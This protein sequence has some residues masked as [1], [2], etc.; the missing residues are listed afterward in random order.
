LAAEKQFNQ[1]QTAEEE[2]KRESLEAER[3]TQIILQA[4]K[5]VSLEQARSNLLFFSKLDLLSVDADKLNAV[6]AEGLT[7]QTGGAVN[8]DLGTERFIYRVKDDEVHVQIKFGLES[9]G[10]STIKLDTGLI[11]KLKPTERAKLGPGNELIGSTLFIAGTVNRS[12]P[13]TGSSTVK[14]L[15]SGGEEDSEIERKILFLPDS[16]TNRFQF[17]VEFR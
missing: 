2:L 5:N 14:I 15:L 8:T 7:P 9:E 17:F 4:T 13:N 16:T 12:D 10:S 3:E 11:Q 1:S 6:F